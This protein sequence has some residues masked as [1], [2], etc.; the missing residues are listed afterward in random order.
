MK[1]CQGILETAHSSPESEI[2]SVNSPFVLS[3]SKHE[4]RKIPP[5][6]KLRANGD[7]SGNF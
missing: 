5:F 4:G 1:A 2:R 3:V 6:D 7:Y